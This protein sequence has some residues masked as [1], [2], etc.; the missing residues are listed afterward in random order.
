MLA[1]KIKPKITKVIDKFPTE[2]SIMRSILNEYG[3]PM[4]ALKICD[5]RGFWHDGTSYGGARTTFIS[6]GGKVK[7]H[8][9][10]Y[11]MVVYDELSTLIREGDFFILDNVKYEIIDLGNCNNMNI[12]FDM[13]LRKCK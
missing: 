1:N 11:L 8:K 7:N 13:L 4:Q 10:N 5:I 2:V 12:Y 9:Q 3:E 6:D